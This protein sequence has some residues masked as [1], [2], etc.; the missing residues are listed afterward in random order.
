LGRKSGYSAL[1]IIDKNR[2]VTVALL[3]QSIAIEIKKNT[4][5]KPIDGIIIFFAGHGAAIVTA[6][7]NVSG[8]MAGKEVTEIL[9]ALIV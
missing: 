4:K 2:D 1:L 8:A 6:I 9:G 3:R 5:N 7:G